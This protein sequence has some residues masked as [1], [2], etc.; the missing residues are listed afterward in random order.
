MHEFL[1]SAQQAGFSG[2]VR[3]RKG[4]GMRRAAAARKGIA[5]RRAGSDPGCEKADQAF[6]FSNEPSMSFSTFSAFRL[7]LKVTPFK[8]FNRPVH[9]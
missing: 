4:N 9:S 3:T 2:T 5:A 8:V 1:E 7:A 6:S